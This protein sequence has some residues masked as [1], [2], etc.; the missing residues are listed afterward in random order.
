M[1]VV[2]SAG[3]DEVLQNVNEIA[4]NVKAITHQLRRSFG[5]EEAGDRLQA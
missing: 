5:T 4:E 3:T 1:H 2:Q